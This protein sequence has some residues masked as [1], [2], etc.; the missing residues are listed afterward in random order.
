MITYFQLLTLLVSQ[1]MNTA[2][3]VPPASQYGHI[4]PSVSESLYF[5]SKDSAGESAKNIQ[6]I[7]HN[8]HH[9][10]HNFQGT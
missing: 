10:V 6:V 1:M 4:S 9:F 5:E 8:A 2:W 3:N 7:Q